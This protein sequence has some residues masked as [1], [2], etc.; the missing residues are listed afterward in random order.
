MTGKRKISIHRFFMQCFAQH[1]LHHFL[2]AESEERNNDRYPQ[3]ILVGVK[4]ESKEAKKCCEQPILKGYLIL[5]DAV[6][7]IES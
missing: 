3:R 4:G 2:S 7:I 1:S 5:K 6:N